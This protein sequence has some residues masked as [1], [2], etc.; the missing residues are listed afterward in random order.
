[1]RAKLAIRPQEAEAAISRIRQ[2]RRLFEDLH[3]AENSLESNYSDWDRP[4][5]EEQV[6]SIRRQMTR[7]AQDVHDDLSRRGL[8]AASL[9]LHDAPIMGGRIYRV[10]LVEALI[11]GAARTY[12]VTPDTIR[13][14]R[15]LNF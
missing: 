13:I 5:L 12:H 7:L 1:M 8:E 9:I 15:K 10:P 2:F 3:R 14:S 4:P 6:R 11:N